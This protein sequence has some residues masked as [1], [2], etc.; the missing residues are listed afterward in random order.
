M[1]RTYTEAQKARKAL[2]SKRWRRKNRERHRAATRKWQE[3]NAER[4]ASVA[5]SWRQANREQIS[6]RQKATRETFTGRARHLVD[7]A[8]LRARRRDVPCS[9][10]WRSVKVILERG[11]CQATGLPFVLTG[12][13]GT[14]V[15]PFSP[16]LDRI[17]Q[18]YGYTPTNT[19][20]VV[21][22]FN[23]GRNGWDDGVYATV[24]LAF[25]KEQGKQHGV[26]RRRQSCQ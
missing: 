18:R 25:L 26:Q 8:R 20:V 5:A 2:T 6:A 11:H 3:E 15:H 17:D 21:T 12:G 16:S 7:Q 24:A 23:V 10:R 14:R 1:G 9:V 13:F 19:R 4:V 22:A